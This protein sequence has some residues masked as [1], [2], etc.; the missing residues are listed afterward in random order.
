M[1]IKYTKTITTLVVTLASSLFLTLAHAQPGGFGPPGGPPGGPRGHRHP[2][3]PLM[4][5]LDVNTNGVLEAAEIAN[6][7]AALLKLDKNR[8]GKLSA[9][10]LI[11]PPPPGSTNQFRFGPRP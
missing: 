9:D 1:K 6:A 5:A 3:L 7:S 11:P 4:I 8:D 10:E 2:P